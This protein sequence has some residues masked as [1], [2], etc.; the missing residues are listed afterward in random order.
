VKPKIIVAVLLATVLVV[1]GCGRDSGGTPTATTPP[2]AA[3]VD[4][5]D[6][7]G[8]CQ[9]G[10]STSSPAQGVTATQIKLGV[11]SDIGF[12]KNSEFVDAATV[13]TSWCNDAGGINGRKLAFNVHDTKLLEVRQRMLE[14]CDQDFA[15]VGGG[16][17]LDAL[18]VQDR[19]NCLL[20]DFP[21]QVTQ[22]QNVSS[23]LQ[24]NQTSGAAYF[25]YT[26][27][28]KWLTKEA[29]PG[30]AGAV[31]FIYGDSPVTKVI[32][33]QDKE[34]L[35]SLGGTASYSDAYPVQGVVDWTPYAQAIK[36]KGVKGLVFLGDFLNLS[37]LEQVLTSIQYKLDWIDANNNAYNPAF[38]QLAG[39]SLGYQN[40]LADLGGI[41]PL[42][43]ADK[44]PAT[45]A[46][47]AL[48]AKYAP[49]A[50]VT[51]PALRAFSSWLLFAKSAASCGDALTR[52][53]LYTAA[54]KE[55][56]WTGRGLQ[57][58]IDMSTDAPLKCFNVEKAT[59]SG[60]QPADFKPDT[61]AYRCDAPA[62]KFTGSYGKALT[63]AD[64]GKSMSDLK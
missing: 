8:I 32:L 51:L 18:G 62:F 28:Y 29:Y 61:G 55:T 3:A 1:S 35:A 44:N 2:G 20:P 15:L 21:A 58:P 33:D 13:F 27:Y 38:L 31:G 36:A 59:P 49:K 53:C 5:N 56:A 9:A 4:F 10:S 64:V 7:K 39:P 46:V 14:A 37:K 6:L 34:A 16:A 26:G 40:N 43:N 17:A 47:V 42:E 12:T 25:R 63:L 22:V 57:A 45:K 19:L 30:S 52:T 48:F 50:Q 23:D 54:R 41:Y 60:W 24:L 11:F